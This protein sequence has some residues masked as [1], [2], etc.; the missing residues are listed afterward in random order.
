MV[1]RTSNPQGVDATQRDEAPGRRGL[2]IG[3]QAAVGRELAPLVLLWAGW[4]KTCRYVLVV[5]HLDD[6]PLPFPR[7][8]RHLNVVT[9]SVFALGS[10]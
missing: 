3:V 10:T 8:P 2:P 1:R 4:L 6:V 5:V 7:G 9:E